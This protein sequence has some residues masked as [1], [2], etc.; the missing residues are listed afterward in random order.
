[1]KTS[2][3]RT[4]LLVTMVLL[5]ATTAIAGAHSASPGVLPPTS[6]VQG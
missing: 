3:M 6:R 5:L 1:M 4:A 2:R